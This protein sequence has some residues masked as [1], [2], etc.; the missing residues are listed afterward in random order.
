MAFARRLPLTPPPFAPRRL[1]VDPA[2]RSMLKDGAKYVPRLSAQEFNENFF[3][4]DK[5]VPGRPA[6][7]WWR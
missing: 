1:N 7:T 3:V 6:G 5:Q 4:K 2:V